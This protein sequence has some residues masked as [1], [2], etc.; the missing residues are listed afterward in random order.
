MFVCSYAR[1]LPHMKNSTSELPQIVCACYFCPQF[2]LPASVPEPLYPMT[3]MAVHFTVDMEAVC[4]TLYVCN[5]LRRR[6]SSFLAMP[7]VSR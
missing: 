4:V 5:F 1:L 3:N 7:P 2:G 6:R